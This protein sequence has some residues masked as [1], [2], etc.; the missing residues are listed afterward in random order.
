MQLLL[1]WDSESGLCVKGRREGGAGCP[2][3]SSACLEGLLDHEVFEGY[4]RLVR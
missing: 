4:I 2:K 3:E 1:A